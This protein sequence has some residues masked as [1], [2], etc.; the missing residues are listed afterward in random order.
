MA[1]AVGIEPEDRPQAIWWIKILQDD[2]LRIVRALRFAAKL[3]F[4]LHHTFF[5]VVWQTCRTHRIVHDALAHPKCRRLRI[6]PSQ[7]PFAL[8]ALKRK[9]AGSRKLMEILKIAKVGNQ[10][11]KDF[12]LLCFET[13]FLLP[14][15]G[16]ASPG[17]SG[18]LAP[19]MFGGCNADGQS[20]YMPPIRSFD[21]RKFKGL[22]ADP[23]KRSRLPSESDAVLRWRY[24]FLCTPHFSARCTACVSA[25]AIEGTFVDSLCR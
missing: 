14:C 18:C 11:L 7:V 20:R 2:P 9:V 3:Q 25:I 12:F 17:G 22:L 1:S 24:S 19:G 8:D 10:S 16:D 15:S 5:Q 6:L 23:V 21:G 13:R 4:E